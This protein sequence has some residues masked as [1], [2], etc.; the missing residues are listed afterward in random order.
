M[1]SR[2]STINFR[3]FYLQGLQISFLRVTEQRGDAVV[4][5]HT[6]NVGVPPQREDLTNDGHPPQRAFNQLP[7]LCVAHLLTMEMTEGR[8]S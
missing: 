7:D 2:D 5:P 3:F 8:F 6:A 1:I 4:V